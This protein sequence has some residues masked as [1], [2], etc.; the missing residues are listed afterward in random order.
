MISSN[1]KQLIIF[2]AKAY[3]PI[4]STILNKKIWTYPKITNLEIPTTDN[5]KKFLQSLAL[6]IIE[7]WLYYPKNWFDQGLQFA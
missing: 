4:T 7:V 3:V 2:N 6:R 5:S 1:I